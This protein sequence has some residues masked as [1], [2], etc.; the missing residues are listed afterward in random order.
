MAKR[1]PSNGNGQTLPP[2]F[3]LTEAERLSL[4]NVQLKQ[5]L[6]QQQMATW[7]AQVQ[8]AHGYDLTRYT[9]DVTTGQCVLKPSA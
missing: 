8:A 2:K 4:E 9:I 3:T 6:A 7:G 1:K 5:Q